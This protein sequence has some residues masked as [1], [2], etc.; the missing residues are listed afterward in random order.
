MDSFVRNFF[1]WLYDSYQYSLLESFSF[2]FF[3]YQNQALYLLNVSWLPLKETNLCDVTCKPQWFCMYCLCQPSKLYFSSL[4]TFN[5]LTFTNLDKYTTP[6]KFFRSY[7]I[8]AFGGKVIYVRWS[9]FHLLIASISIICGSLPINYNMYYW[10]FFTFFF[11]FLFCYF[12]YLCLFSYYCSRL[13]H[14]ISTQILHH[15]NGENEDS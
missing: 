12:C 5:Q 11:L 4:V 2:F 13:Y 9:R 10:L 8:M 3:S 14:L 6:L 7:S 1:K 15:L